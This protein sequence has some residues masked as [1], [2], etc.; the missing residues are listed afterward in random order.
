[1]KK[2]TFIILLFLT[3]L[4][5]SCS[6][7]SQDV[8]T[9][10]PEAKIF[11][12][13]K[14]VIF[15]DVSII[16]NNNTL[17]PL[18]Q[19]LIALGVPNDDRHIKWDPDKKSVTILKDTTEIYLQQDATITYL[20]GKELELDVP[21]IGYDKNGLTYVP[22][23]FITQCLGRKAALDPNSGN[24]YISDEDQKTIKIGAILPISGVISAYGTQM[25][26]ALILAVE[27]INS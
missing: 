11:I 20:N 1:M 8:I 17:L 12:D 18:R 10:K 26:D 9:E 21:P 2:V 3:V 13:G 22:V 15:T 23:S 6:T 24:I 7:Y 14:Q 27:E 5:L 25:R 19:L 16:V 4:S